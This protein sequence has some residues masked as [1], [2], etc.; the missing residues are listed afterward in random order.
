M[1][2]EL[3]YQELVERL[4]EPLVERH[5]AGATGV[6][7]DNWP[8]GCLRI[9]RARVGEADIEFIPCAEHAAEFSEVVVL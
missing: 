4:G 7:S 5:L 9:I 2:E 3:A 8:C 6:R 1:S